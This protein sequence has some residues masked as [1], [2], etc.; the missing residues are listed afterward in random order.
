MKVPTTLGGPAATPIEGG[1]FTAIYAP[2]GSILAKSKNQYSEEIVTADV[3]LDDIHRHKQMADCIGIPPPL[4][5]E[6]VPS[7]G[8]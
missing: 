5:G 4:S 2:D 3:D 1:G 8:S 7:R 6:D